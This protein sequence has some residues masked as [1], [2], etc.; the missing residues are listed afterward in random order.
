MR[1][2]RRKEPEAIPERLPGVVKDDFKGAGDCAFGTNQLAG[3]TPSGTLSA[4]IY[5]D[6]FNGIIF[7]H[8]NATLADANA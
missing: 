5:R 6:D 7:H 2:K 1:N 8:Q 4:I 3:V